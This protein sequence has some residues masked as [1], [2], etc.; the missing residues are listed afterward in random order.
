[1]ARALAS[2][3]RRWTSGRGCSGWRTG[4]PPWA[5]PRR[6]RLTPRATS[7]TGRPLRPAY[8]RFWTPGSRVGGPITGTPPQPGSRH[9]TCAC[10]A[11]WRH[12]A[13]I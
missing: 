10:E 1:M 9:S 8:G 11:R 6:R 13:W 3:P 12:W 2:A 5:S 4:L 7:S